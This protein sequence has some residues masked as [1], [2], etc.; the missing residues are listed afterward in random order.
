MNF[1]K[2]AF[3]FVL[4]VLVVVIFFLNLSESGKL[5]KT[6]DLEFSLKL[7]RFDSTFFNIK[8][9]NLEDKL[10]AL[11]EEYPAFFMGTS[12]QFWVN[13]KQDELQKKLYGEVKRELDF[14]VIERDIESLLQ[15]YYG[16]YPNRPRFELTTYIS[17]LDFYSPIIIQDSLQQIFLA[18]QVPVQV[19]LPVHVI[20][21]ML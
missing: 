9:E 10:P 16:F 17:N 19:L 8:Q 11:R 13:Q 2:K 21:L 14:N 18:I 15:H 5:N 3:W 20:F 7:N 12:D 4:P 1:L 6:S